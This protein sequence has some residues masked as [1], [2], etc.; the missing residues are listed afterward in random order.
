MSTTSQQKELIK[1]ITALVAE[2]L[3]VPEYQITEELA[4]GELPEWDSLG[5]MNIM[6]ALED[7]YGI[8]DYY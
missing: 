8:T 3:A 4:Y 6:M 5:H 2:T 1:M 7:K